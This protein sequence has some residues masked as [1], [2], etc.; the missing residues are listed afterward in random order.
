[1]KNLRVF[2]ITVVL[3]ILCASGAAFAGEI[4][5]SG[6]ASVDVMS[7]YVWRGQKLSNSWVVQP[8]VA[9]TYGVF[10]ANL[11][12]NYDSD[13]KVDEGDGWREEHTGLHELEFIETRRHWFTRKVEHNTHGGVNVIC[14]VEGEEI[15]VESPGKKF[16]PFIVHYAEVFIVPAIVGRYSIR[17]Y[18]DSE[19]QE[20]ATIKAFV[21]SH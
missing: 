1:M 21:R 7:N 4:E 5:T 11:W 17:P 9:I 15:I 18:G 19:G 16:E 13:A 14:L 2:S 20:C 10:G 6:S 12:A 3:A 8:S